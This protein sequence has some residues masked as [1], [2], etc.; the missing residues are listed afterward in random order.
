MYRLD[1]PTNLDSVSISFS[2]DFT[3]VSYLVNALSSNR[4]PKV[5]LVEASV[6]SELSKEA[7][8]RVPARTFW[9]GIKRQESLD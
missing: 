9:N 3:S 8:W 5:S 4:F 2:M 1:S 6:E 7:T